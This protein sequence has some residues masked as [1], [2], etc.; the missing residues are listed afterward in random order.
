MVVA[1]RLDASATI[2]NGHVSRCRSLALGLLRSGQVGRVCFACAAIPDSW[3]CRL[4]EDGIEVMSLTSQLSGSE[5][6]SLADPA[7]DAAELRERLVSLGRVEWLVT[8]HYG[9]GAEWQRRLRG[10]TRCILAIDDLADRRHD[11]EILVDQNFDDRPLDRYLP[12]IPPLSRALVGPRF[13][14]LA[15]DY[16]RLRG[17]VLR[18]PDPVRR[19]AVLLGPA[20]VF[21]VTGKA[22]V[23][24]GRSIPWPV[25]I[26][27]VLG[28]DHPFAAAIA[29]QASRSATIRLH[30]SVA[31]MASLFARADLAIGAAGAAALERACL[32][33][34]ALFTAIAGNQLPVAR[35]LAAL[36][37]ALWLGNAADVS[38]ELIADR[39]RLVA[40]G[41]HPD[42]SAAC[43]PDV[44]GQGV[45]RIVSEML[46][47]I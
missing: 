17:A 41:R 46:T 20:D 21:N 8:D 9:I 39:L 31:G 14:L 22:L 23:A 10:A 32:R 19:I 42:L 18:T 33:L 15:D 13:A 36:A 38:E 35:A 12:L 26:D 45:D 40:D 27:V 24:I 16:A 47:I 30:R 11:C 5:P 28:G 6:W 7:A 34:P 2:G 25:E 44:D 1:F 4:E 3:R 29:E 37:P 43:M